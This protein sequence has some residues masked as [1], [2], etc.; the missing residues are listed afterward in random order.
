MLR[1]FCLVRA[2]ILFSCIRDERRSS[3]EPL[4]STTELIKDSSSLSIYTS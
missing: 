1:L 3:K 2:D 4:P